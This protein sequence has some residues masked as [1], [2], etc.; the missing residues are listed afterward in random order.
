MFESVNEPQFVNV[1]NAK[2][3][4]LLDELNTSFFHIVRASGVPMTFVRLYCRR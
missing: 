1:D 4:E 2:Q 3:N